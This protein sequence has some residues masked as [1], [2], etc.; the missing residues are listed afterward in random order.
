MAK[1]PQGEIDAKVES[2]AAKLNLTE[3][4]GRKP[5]QLSGGQRQR[6]AIGRAIVREPKAFLLDEPLSNLDAA[7]RVQMRLELARL[8]RDLA[9]TMIYVTHDQVEAMTLAERIVVMRAGAIEQVG[10]PLELYNNPANTFVAGFIGSP[11]MNLLE[12][13]VT[14]ASGKD[15][16]LQLQGESL[17][18]L[19]NKVKIAASQRLTVGIRPE[20]LSIT[21][22]GTIKGTIAAIEHLD[23]ETLAYV[24]IGNRTLVTAKIPSSTGVAVGHPIWLVVS[25]GEPLLF[26]EHGISLHRSTARQ[27]N[28][29]ACENR[30]IDLHSA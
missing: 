2:A 3:Y 26:N 15:I 16:T 6:V 27:T 28:G 20:A 7:L 18:K 4:L 5:R 21:K 11:K 22:A 12:A 8:H 17:L 25:A 10:S 13:T 1:V 24:D 29:A 30:L 19:N 14:Q 23:S 9:T